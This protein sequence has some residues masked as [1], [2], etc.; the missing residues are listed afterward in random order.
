MNLI[1]AKE[2]AMNQVA[3]IN[4]T[5]RGKVSAKPDGIRI[6]L[7]VVSQD[8]EYSTA[9]AD[10]NKRV[11]AIGDAILRAD[12]TET[13]VT[14]KYEIEDV[15][16]DKYDVEKNKFVGYKATQDLTVTLPLDTSLLGR[17]IGELAKSNSK[18][19][20]TITFVIRNHDALKKEARIAAAHNAK[21]AASDLAVA[22]GLQLVSV[23]SIVFSA[24]SGGS[25][26][27]GASLR[28]LSD[29]GQFD[30]PSMSVTPDVISHDESVQMVWLATQTAMP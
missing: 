5:G 2:Q 21:E 19:G 4:V 6:G 25:G 10:L 12:V 9:M 1:N 14:K 29:L 15:W 18:P 7:S 27:S 24:G 23:K 16:S 30:A 26:G 28:H 3:E 13:P 11:R 20:L 8:P 17:V 22:A